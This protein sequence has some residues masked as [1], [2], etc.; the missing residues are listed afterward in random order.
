MNAISMR[1]WRNAPITNYPME[2]EDEQVIIEMPCL[3]SDLKRV[4]MKINWNTL[5]GYYITKILCASYQM[6]K[7]WNLWRTN[8]YLYQ[9]F[10][11]IRDIC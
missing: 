11:T 9:R 6:F 1:G 4:H 8:W 10:T 7:R 2:D 3:R 5:L